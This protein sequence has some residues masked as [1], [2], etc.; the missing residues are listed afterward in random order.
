MRL[1]P[2]FM[3]GLML[4]APAAS[5]APPGEAASLPAVGDWPVELK[6]LPKMAALGVAPAGFLAGM[7]VYSAAK[8]SADMTK[9]RKMIDEGVYGFQL[10]KRNH[11]FE[12]YTTRL[13]GADAAAFDLDSG[14]I[15][16]I[17]YFYQRM[18]LAR[19]ESAI[20]EFARLDPK[21]EVTPKLAEDAP[22]HTP[23]PSPTRVVITV[24]GLR[25]ICSV[26]RAI[27]IAGQQPNSPGMIVYETHPTDWYLLTHKP[28][29]NIAEAIRNGQIIP[30]MTEE[31]VNAA[32]P[33][34]RP[35]RQA[36][37]DNR[38][39]YLE[40]FSITTDS[41]SPRAKVWITAGKVRDAQ[42]STRKD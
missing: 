9:I 20:R 36:S 37:D 11:A 19:G 25:L 7:P 40:F 6:G 13:M 4:L 39:V 31:E 27:G 10:E 41:A 35:R 1:A 17:G 23:P 42:M 28:D 22:P 15:S 8:G 5:S 18:P 21:A 34:C 32:M 33:D 16:R 26:Q 14:R 24:S 29:D 12:W 3:V 38:L 2:W 30:G